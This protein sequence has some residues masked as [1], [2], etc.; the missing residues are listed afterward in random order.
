VAHALARA[1]LDRRAPHR[2]RCARPA[3]PHS[4]AGS[5]IA[6]SWA[7]VR[8]RRFRRAAG[9]ASPSARNPRDRLA[10][11]RL[12]VG[13]ELAAAVAE[14]VQLALEVRI[15][16]FEYPG[17]WRLNFEVRQNSSLRGP[18]FDRESTQRTDSTPLARRR[19][20]RACGA[21]KGVVS[22]ENRW[23]E[24][25][26]AGRPRGG[27]RTPPCHGRA[28]R[29]RRFSRSRASFAGT[30]FPRLA[31]RRSAGG[32]FPARRP[33]PAPLTASAVTA[34]ASA[35]VAAQRLNESSRAGAVVVL[36]GGPAGGGCIARWRRSICAIRIHCGNAAADWR[37]SPRPNTANAETSSQRDPDDHVAPGARAWARAF[38]RLARSAA[39]C[40]GRSW[41][42]LDDFA[43][44]VPPRWRVGI[45][46]YVGAAGAGADDLHAKRLP[47][48]ENTMLVCPVSEDSF[49]TLPPLSAATLGQKRGQ[50]RVSVPLDVSKILQ[51]SRNHPGSGADAKL[52]A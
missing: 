18:R 13:A 26:A 22:L 15:A 46:P 29:C 49:T 11:R 40:V 27:R 5:S 52:Q 12:D 39:R 44:S 31:T 42:P 8:T 20:F 21:S 10:R 28:R 25:K 30:Q 14:G 4:A 34:G 2:A 1:R 35:G 41:R 47:P 7:L 16:F 43:P 19:P 3:G 45:A 48:E 33:A 6:S 50:H 24:P 17:S 51:V 23:R 38:R 37:R 9:P 32:P 36:G